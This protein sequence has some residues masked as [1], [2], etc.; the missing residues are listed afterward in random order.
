MLLFLWV[1]ENREKGRIFEKIVGK[2]LP[3]IARELRR[4]EHLREYAG[5]YML[6]FLCLVV[7]VRKFE[8]LGIVKRSKLG[9]VISYI[10]CI[11]GF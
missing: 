1:G 7:F 10:L 3:Y 2:D 5:R 9:N 8:N 4:I 11:H 6:I